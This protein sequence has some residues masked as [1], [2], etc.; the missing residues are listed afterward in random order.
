[1]AL[2]GFATLQAFAAMAPQHAGFRSN[3]TAKPPPTHGP[4]V[5]SPE[6]EAGAAAAGYVD[7]RRLRRR[8]SNRESARRSRA[9]KQRCLD[10]L[11]D[12]TARLEGT[13]RELTARAQ[14]ARGRLAL[15]RLANAGLRAE[16]AALA[17]RALALGHLYAAA[18]AGSSGG[19]FSL[20]FVDIEQT[21][22][23]L[24]A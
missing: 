9:R 22:A 18:T 7:E 16:V 5:D 19:A 10:E 14:A 24:I 17:R 8:I 20:G 1:M 23:S 11:R 3:D 15:I 12:R 21:I 13:K 6:V 2:S 4:A